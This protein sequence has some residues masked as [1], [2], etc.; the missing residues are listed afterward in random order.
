MSS[1]DVSFSDES[2]IGTIEADRL[3]ESGFR[4]ELTLILDALPDRRSHPR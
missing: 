3:L 1:S 2:P 4:R